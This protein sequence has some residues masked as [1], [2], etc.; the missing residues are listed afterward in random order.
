MSSALLFALN[1][2]YTLNLDAADWPQWRG[3]QRDGISA[4]TNLLREWPKNGPKLMWKLTDLGSGYSAPAVVKDRFYLLSNE[5][6]ENEF[7]Q[8]H[9]VQDGGRIWRTRI[10]KVGPNIP[11]MNYPGARSTPTIEGQVLYALGSDGDVICLNL[12]DGKVFWQKNLRTELG[13]QPGSWA[14]AESPLVDG[15]KLI[16]TPGGT[17][18]AMV[19]FNKLSGEVVWKCSTPEQDRAAYASPIVVETEGIRQYVQLLEKGLIG[20]EA[21]SGKVLWRY[22]KAI[23]RYG[24]NIPTP[25]ASDG[26]VY[27]GSAGTGGGAV[28]LA[29]K[30]GAM[31]VEE[32]YFGA[33]MPTAIGGAVK[34]GDHLF[35]TTAQALLCI[36]F[37]TGKVIWENRGLGAASICFA[38]GN[39]YLHGENG[40]AAMVEASAQGYRELG[41][42][43]PPNQ[44]PHAQSMEKDWAYPV[45]AN[46]RL[47]IRDRGSFWCYSVAQPGKD[48]EV[49]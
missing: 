7:V 48:F 22:G 45:L 10:G 47:Y 8:A 43:T 9:S 11:E 36:E 41:R 5:G 28:K 13:G 4:E 37:K 12:T 35:G 39:L 44:A 30:N 20:V 32:I 27:V 15:E 26:Y 25:I 31:T 38:D 42:F 19:A 14:Y 18:A 24:A 21:K 3:P 1:S 29:A 17:N 46:G 49:N 23:S 34:V 33:K 40:D 6:M 2:I 16:C